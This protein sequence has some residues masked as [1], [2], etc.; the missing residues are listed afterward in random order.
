[1]HHKLASELFPRD[2]CCVNTWRRQAPDA[3]RAPNSRTDITRE[4]GWSSSMLL[5]RSHTTRLPCGQD[6]LGVW[7]LHPQYRKISKIGLEYGFTG[8]V[9]N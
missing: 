8:Q 6:K 9:D 7:F 5:A 3:I 1:M 2:K 4:E